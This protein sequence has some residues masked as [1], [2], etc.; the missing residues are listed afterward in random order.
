MED[1]VAGWLIIVSVVWVLMVVLGAWV[2]H[3]KGR[4]RIVGGVVG[5][6]FGIFGVIVLAIIPANRRKLWEREQEWRDER[7]AQSPG[8]AALPVVGS[9]EEP[10]L[11]ERADGRPW[12]K[13]K[14]YILGVPILAIVILAAVGAALGDTESDD[15]ATT[16]PTQ[17]QS[18]VTE[19][20]S[21]S[22]TQP[23]AAATPAATAT[24]AP[25]PGVGAT[26]RVGDLDLTILSAEP[27][28]ASGYNRFNDANYRVR[29]HATNS[30]GAANSE[31]NVSTSAFKLVDSTG[32]ALSSETCS[33]CPE[34][35]GSGVELIKG[36]S[37][38]GAVYFELPAGRD[39]VELRYQPLFSTNR[40]VIPLR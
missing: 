26:L 29:F 11:S 8:D 35:L 40:V 3:G 6:I 4:S 20:A 38:E 17:A 37:F 34:A 36:G 31:Y 23:A 13:K 7:A 32:V 9:R 39:V 18:T 24:T 19:S 5:G 28:D 30:R 25:T 33:G 10:V 12:Y 1:A 27:F 15:G 22:S 21:V 16:Q 14:R 2:N